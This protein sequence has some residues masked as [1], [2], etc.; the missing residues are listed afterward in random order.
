[1]LQDEIYEL[2]TK[3]SGWSTQNYWLVLLSLTLFS[4][5]DSDGNSRLYN[6]LQNFGKCFSNEASRLSGTTDIKHRSDLSTPR[7]IYS[8]FR[9]RFFWFL[10]HS[11]STDSLSRNDMFQLLEISLML[12]LSGRKNTN[13][14]L[15]STSAVRTKNVLC[16]SYLP[17]C[18]NRILNV[19]SQQNRIS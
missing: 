14:K 1:M 13:I 16:G 15:T 8:L 3:S 4:L 7:M 5:F 9:T 17:F 19:I 6:E 10:S 12:T 18:R 11:R 2:I